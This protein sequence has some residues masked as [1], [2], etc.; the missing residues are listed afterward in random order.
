MELSKDADKM[1]C[2]LYKLYLKMRKHVKE[3]DKEINVYCY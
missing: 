2:H 1:V 3:Q